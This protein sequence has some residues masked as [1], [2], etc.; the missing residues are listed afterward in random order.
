[1]LMAKKKKGTK[2][3]VKRTKKKGPKSCKCCGKVLKDSDEMFRKEFDGKTR[4]F[5]SKDCL[6]EYKDEMRFREHRVLKDDDVEEIP[7]GGSARAG[8]IFTAVFILVLIL[9]AAIAATPKIDILPPKEVIYQG[10]LDTIYDDDI[11]IMQVKPHGDGYTTDM[12][13]EISLSNKGNGDIDNLIVEVLA[14]NQTTKVMD[15]GFN[16]STFNY[17][18]NG[19]STEVI[20]VKKTVNARGSLRLPPGTFLLR[21][22]LYE[23]GYR[24]LVEG[25]K[26]VTVTEGQVQG[27]PWQKTGGDGRSEPDQKLES[28]PGFELVGVVAAIAVVIYVKRGRKRS[29]K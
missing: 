22:K 3:A 13:V 5:C 26:T 17:V 12:V 28:T 21:I 9:G 15:D 2:K 14:E 1:M 25:Q 4:T 6:Q 10:E 18:G 20:P 16:T 23:E 19:T 24:S 8:I 7:E 11:R 27:Q 29:R